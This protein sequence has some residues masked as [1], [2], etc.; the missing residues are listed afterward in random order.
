M[1][2]NFTVRHNVASHVANANHA[3]ACGQKA[4]C[5]DTAV[6]PTLGRKRLST[7]ASYRPGAMRTGS[8]PERSGSSRSATSGWA[9]A[10]AGEM[11][12]AIWAAL[13]I[14]RALSS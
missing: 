6:K 3:V 9:S 7:L 2:Q 5:I 13:V 10:E 14:S 1:H 11:P 4:D 8:M 12:A